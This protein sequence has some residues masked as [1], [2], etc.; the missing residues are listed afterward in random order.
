MANDLPRIDHIIIACKDVLV[1]AKD[2][3]QRFG[4]ASYEGGKHQGTVC[5]ILETSG[6][7]HRSQRLSFMQVG[8][9]RTTSPLWALATLSWLPV[10]AASSCCDMHGTFSSWHVADPALWWCSVR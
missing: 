10:R 7:R 6:C 8:A 2:I 4:L 5:I 1:A 3:Y 9:P